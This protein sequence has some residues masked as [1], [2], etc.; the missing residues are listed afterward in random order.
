ML[1]PDDE[2]SIGLFFISTISTTYCRFKTTQTHCVYSKE[3]IQIVFIF[4]SHA[5]VEV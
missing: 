4:R 1:V 2:I 5:N 3:D